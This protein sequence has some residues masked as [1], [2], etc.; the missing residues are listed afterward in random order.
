MRILPFVCLVLLAA[1]GGGSS[2]SN[3]PASSPGPGVNSNGTPTGPWEYVATSTSK[4]GLITYVEVN[5]GSANAAVFQTLT[6]GTSTTLVGDTCNVGTPTVTVTVSGNSVSGTFVIGT[7]TYTFSGSVT[8]STSASGTYTGG[9]G[10]CADAGN[11]QANQASSF[12]GNYT[13]ELTYSDGS[14]VNVTMA[15]T[16]G[17]SP[18]YGVTA[19]GTVTNISGSD[20]STG[21]CALQL[22]GT[23]I[24]NL[25]E[26]I[27][28]IGEQSS[29]ALG[30]W[31][32]DGVLDVS[33][34]QGGWY[35][36]SLTKQ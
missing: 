12:N 31:L 22:S 9:A 14:K 7:N 34:N 19:N 23:G 29:T 28:P 11:F 10:T 1:C 26:V 6:V 3:S 36:G 24:G 16:E 21:P 17:G 4:P 30:I 35:D 25:A 32:H 13:G 2:Q 8:S 33:E 20:C 27:G 18:S 15:I 5:F